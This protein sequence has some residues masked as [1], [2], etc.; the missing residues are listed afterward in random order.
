M[1]FPWI[2]C[3]RCGREPQMYAWCGTFIM[4]CGCP[5]PKTH[6]SDHTL[7]REERKALWGA[8]IDSSE[9]QYDIEPKK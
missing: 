8:L 3:P 7:T 9:H 2:T 1:S 4:G 5:P 6:T